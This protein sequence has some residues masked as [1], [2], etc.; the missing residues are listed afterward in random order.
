MYVNIPMRVP[1]P[2]SNGRIA[3]DNV[4]YISSIET[5]GDNSVIF[6]YMKK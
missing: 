4:S 6:L 3:F 2:L 5:S 1:T